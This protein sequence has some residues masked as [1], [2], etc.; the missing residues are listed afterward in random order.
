MKVNYIFMSLDE[1]GKIFRYDIINPRVHNYS[2]RR[3]EERFC[4]HMRK[5][6]NF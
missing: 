1:E 5:K 6:C 4:I 2:F 3:F